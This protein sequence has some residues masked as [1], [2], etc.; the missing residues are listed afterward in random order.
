MALISK[1][2]KNSWLLIVMLALGLGG[3][4]VMDMVSAGSRASGNEFTIGVVNG[5]KLDWNDFQ[6]AERI[7]YPNST[8]DVYGQRNY[9]WNYM[10]EEQLL[11]EESEALGL[12]VSKEEMEE[13]QFGTR[14]S[15]VIQRNFRDPNTGQ[16][17]RATLDQIKTNLGTGNLQP[18]L[19][20]F[21]GFQ[22]GEIIK[23]RLQTKLSNLVKKS[24][25]TPTWMAQQ[26]QAEQGSSL[27]FTYVLVPFDKIADEEVKAED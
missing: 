17:D 10:V 8:G 21:W 1:I 3:F 18:Q 23:D 9:L 25:Y 4:V 7:L 13:L 20:E 24:I 6:R 2:R 12:G 5:K 11:K 15:P 22:S 16:M 26:L 19:E 14:L 27:D